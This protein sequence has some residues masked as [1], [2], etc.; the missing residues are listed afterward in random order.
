MKDYA[1]TE[2]QVHLLREAV[3]AYI[4]TVFDDVDPELVSQLQ[5]IYHILCDSQKDNLN[6]TKEDFQFHPLCDY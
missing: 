1:F 4:E 2:H 6:T 5:D 3:D